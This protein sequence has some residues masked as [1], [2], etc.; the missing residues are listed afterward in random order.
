VAE[1]SEMVSLLVS[2]GKGLWA[3]LVLGLGL[4]SVFC[5]SFLVDA[6]SYPYP[7]G[8]PDGIFESLEDAKNYILIKVNPETA[9]TSTR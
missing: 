3:F 5:F 9:F 4:L 7:E 2:I 6:Q 1:S 8:A